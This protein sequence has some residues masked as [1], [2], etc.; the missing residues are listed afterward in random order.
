MAI[1]AR[2][3]TFA[4]LAAIVMAF[5]LTMLPAAVVWRA[6]AGRGIGSHFGRIA[7]RLRTHGLLVAAQVALSVVLLM[8]AGLFVRTVMNALAVDVT[9]RSDRSSAA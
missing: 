8:G 6:H 2:V 1:D 4:G 3:A 5:L 7:P 9:V